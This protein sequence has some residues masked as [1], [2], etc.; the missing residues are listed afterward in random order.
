MEHTAEYPDPFDLFRIWYDEAGGSSLALPN[1]MSL[2]T[3]RDIGAPASRMVLLSSY[4]R[5]GFVFHTNYESDKGVEITA[6][7]RAAL[8]FWWETLNRQVRIEGA[9]ERTT[10]EESDAYFAGRPRGAKLGAWA[11]DQSRLLPL[12]E[13]LEARFREIESRHEG[14]SVPR[15]PHWGGY[16]L[17]PSLFEFW[18]GREDRLHERI[19]YERTPEGWAAV[20]LCP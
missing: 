14:A 10:A 18:A 3:V 6:C 20:R 15:P 13:T 16:R 5:R 12:R 11:S 4:N 9:V 2:S 17:I 19:R 1:A 8:L 7:P